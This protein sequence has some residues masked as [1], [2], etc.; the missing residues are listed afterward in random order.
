[1]AAN[2]PVKSCPRS[3]GLALISTALA[4]T[5]WVAKG[6]TAKACFEKITSSPPCATARVV[7]SKISLL[8]LPKVN[9]SLGTWI[10]RLIA[11]FNSKPFESG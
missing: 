7:N 11:A 8:P 5:A 2:M 10:F 3:V 6:Y 4:P 9:Q 1:M